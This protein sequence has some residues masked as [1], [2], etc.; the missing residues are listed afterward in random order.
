MVGPSAVAPAGYPH[1]SGGRIAAAGPVCAYGG[2]HGPA[3][4][5]A[6]GL[7]FAKR[8]PRE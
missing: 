5:T 1:S 6:Q 2:S 8:P 4:A 3:F 7:T